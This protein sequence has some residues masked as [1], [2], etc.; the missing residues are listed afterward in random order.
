MHPLGISIHPYHLPRE[1]TLTNIGMSMSILGLAEA[2]GNNLLGNKCTVK[3]MQGNKSRQNK[4][5]LKIQ[6]N[7]PVT[8]AGH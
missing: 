4:Y 2:L 7:H 1:T 8:R 6:P 3:R 5:L